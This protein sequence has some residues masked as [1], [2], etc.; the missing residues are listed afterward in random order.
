MAPRYQAGPKETPFPQILQK[1]GKPVPLHQG[2]HFTYYG[3]KGQ[4][5]IGGDY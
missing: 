4:M 5:A 2:S 3:Q 1:L